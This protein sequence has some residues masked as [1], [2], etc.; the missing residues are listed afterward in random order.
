MVAAL[1][2]HFDTFICFISDELQ[3]IFTK[4]NRRKQSIEFPVSMLCPDTTCNGGWAAGN[5]S[6]R[7]L[8]ETLINGS[9][10][11]DYIVWCCSV[12]VA[13]DKDQ[14]EVPGIPGQSS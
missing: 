14:D 7:R 13:G 11:Q 8:E 6:V 12:V 4:I 5:V 10:A 2:V 9:I 3:N 1:S